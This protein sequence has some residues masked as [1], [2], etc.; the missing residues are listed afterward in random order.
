MLVYTILM[1]LWYSVLAPETRA[2]VVEQRI[3]GEWRYFVGEEA[4]DTP[5]EK[6]IVQVFDFFYTQPRENGIV[7][8]KVT[9]WFFFL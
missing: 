4:K 9:H 3:Q 5:T 1:F 7:S 8:L 6:A 2:A